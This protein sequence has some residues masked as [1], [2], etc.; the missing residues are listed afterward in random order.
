MKD[1][2]GGYASEGVLTYPFF[3]P[4]VVTDGTVNKVE[5]NGNRTSLDSKEGNYLQIDLGSVYDFD[6]IEIAAFPLGKQLNIE[7]SEDGTTWMPVKELVMD[8]VDIE[9]FN[10]LKGLG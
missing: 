5:K 3:D 9:A 8:V 6:R 2:E 4:A 10:D 7:V 1:I